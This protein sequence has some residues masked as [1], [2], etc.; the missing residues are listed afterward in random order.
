MSGN[1]T[2]KPTRK[3]REETARKGQSFRSR[4]F[5]VACLTL[6]GTAYLAS[7][8]SLRSLME[9][10]GQAISFHFQIN[11]AD[12]TEQVF[13]SGM[14]IILPFLALCLFCSALPSILQTGFVL[15]TK[16]LQP[17][18]SALDPTKGIKK[19]FSLRTVKE[20][21]K[22]ILYLGSFIV[23]GMLFWF[24]NKRLVFSQVNGN[25]FVVADVWR[26]LL[27]SLVALCLGCSVIILLLDAL[28]EYF[29]VM[30]DMKMDKEEVKREMK[31]TEGNPEVKS[32]RREI[33]MDILSEQIKSD[34]D[35]SR[36]IIANPTHIAVGIYFRP[37]IAPYPL[38]SVREA[39]LRAVAVR[40]YA[41]KAG[42]P[43]VVD[44]RLARRIFKTHRRYD[45]VNLE[46]VDEILRLLVWL[47]QVENA[48]MATG[49]N[50]P[51]ATQLPDTEEK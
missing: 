10:L 5:I 39:N 11:I 15:A 16:A 22:A 18:L 50:K 23:S 7:V 26:H 31:E 17:R 37:E 9:V 40:Q 6:G 13:C 45:V 8:A 21:V 36:L 38:I 32:R 25:L 24:E 12:Y 28:A 20:A 34:I 44:I 4:D 47:E 35:N 3:R 27:F 41:E 49:M 48:G 29:L 42:I 14:K 1:K 33:H 51:E 2:E 19:I 30:K 46:S 43:V